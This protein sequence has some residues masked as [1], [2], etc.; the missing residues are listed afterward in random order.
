MDYVIP[1]SVDPTVRLIINILVGLHLLAF[2]AYVFLLFR[3]ST[4][5]STDQF[6]DQYKNLQAQAKHKVGKQE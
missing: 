4:K 5:S 6:R 1:A 3:S 2:L